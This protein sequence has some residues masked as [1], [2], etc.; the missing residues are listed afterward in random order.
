MHTKA[1]LNS[2]F[3][4]PFVTFPT[5]FAA[6]GSKQ[7]LNT[8]EASTNPTTNFGNLSHMTEADGFSLWFLPW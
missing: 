3:W 5:A 2:V 6:S 1:M 4:K 7:K 8:S